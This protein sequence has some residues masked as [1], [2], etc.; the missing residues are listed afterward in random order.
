MDIEKIDPEKFWVS[1]INL[2]AVA[3]VLPF[4]SLFVNSLPSSRVTY[5]RMGLTNQTKQ[6]LSHSFINHMQQHAQKPLHIS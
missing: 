5:L 1:D 6:N 3:H 2:L 4:M